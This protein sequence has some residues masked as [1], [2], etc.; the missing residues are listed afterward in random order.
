[1]ASPGRTSSV[2]SRLD[3]VRSSSRYLFARGANRF[4]TSTIRVSASVPT[5]A[6]K[7]MPLQTAAQCANRLTSILQYGE[8]R[9]GMRQEH[10]TSLGQP[11][12]AADALEHRR[13]QLV[14]E[15]V[16][17]TA[18]GRLRAMQPGLGSSETAGFGDREKRRY[19]TNVHRSGT[20][21]LSEILCI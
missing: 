3:A 15:Y 11:C 4:S 20:L 5:R 12:A 2:T 7:I 8:R 9:L 14:F 19:P 16:Q 10:A 17:A 6:S 1:M 21:M 13:T 18:D